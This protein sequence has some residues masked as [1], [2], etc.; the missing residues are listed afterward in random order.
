MGIN[1]VVA[2]TDDDWFEMLRQHLNL[3]EVNFWAPSAA[4]FRAVQFE[5][6]TRGRAARFRLCY[7]A[8]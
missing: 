2:V 6:R 7:A 3:R 5:C 8:A 4:N 1:L